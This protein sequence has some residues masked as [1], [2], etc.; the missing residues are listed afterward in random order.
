VVFKNGGGNGKSKEEGKKLKG[1]SATQ[2]RGG[3]RKIRGERGDMGVTKLKKE[4][5]RDHL[6]NPITG[7]RDPE[8][9]GNKEKE[10][11]K[12]KGKS[13]DHR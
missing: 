5:R 9:R 1:R 10:K 13:K 12:L 6:A 4:I 3:D 7:A 2:G 11:V 8:N